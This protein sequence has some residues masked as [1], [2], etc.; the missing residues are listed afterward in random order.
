MGP[1]FPIFE[2]AIYW[3]PASSPVA[4]ASAFASSSLD[5]S[6]SSSKSC[7]S[8]E[9]DGDS[10]FIIGPCG[11]A[12]FLTSTGA[13]T[14]SDA[15]TSGVTSSMAGTGGVTSSSTGAGG[16][17]SLV[18]GTGGVHSST[19]STGGVSSLAAC[20]NGVNSSATGTGGVTSSVA[21]TSGVNSS[22]AAGTGG[23]T[24]LRS[25]LVDFFCR[26]RFPRLLP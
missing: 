7:G 19:S 14:S 26:A 16:V 24:S 3:L 4:L 6:V 21:G 22:S 1:I 25:F 9:I 11:V 8:S 12:P 5:F 20:T 23:V 17:T 10:L 18:A 13:V 15:G 2:I